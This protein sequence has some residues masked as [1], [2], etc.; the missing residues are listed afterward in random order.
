MTTAVLIAIAFCGVFV[1]RGSPPPPPPAP[2]KPVFMIQQSRKECGL[3]QPGD[4]FSLCRAPKG[5]TAHSAERSLIIETPRGVCRITPPPQ[6]AD[7]EFVRSC[8]RMLNLKPVID[9]T[10]LGY[11]EFSKNRRDRD[12]RLRPPQ[13]CVPRIDDGGISV[14]ESRGEVTY[15][16]GFHLAGST[17]ECR[18]PS[19]WIPYFGKTHE[20]MT[21][22]FGVCDDYRDARAEDCCRELGL[23]VT[24]P[25]ATDCAPP[26]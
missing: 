12:G 16:V 4:E 20:T 24:R 25:R 19:D 10:T 8:A 13:K 7:A 6:K 18:L 9:V 11:P 26:G 3:F 14:N 15:R 21:T 22:P 1:G 23:K 2:A 5:W 17:D